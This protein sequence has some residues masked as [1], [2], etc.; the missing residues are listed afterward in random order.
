MFGCVKKLFRKKRKYPVEK[1]LSYSTSY[2]IMYNNFTYNSKSIEDYS[3]KLANKISKEDRYALV[4]K[5]TGMPRELVGCIHHLEGEGDFTR[6]LHNGESL[7]NVNKHGTRLEPKHRGKGLNWSWEQAAIDAINL[8]K[9]KFP[10]LWSA[11][12]SLDFLEKYNGTGYRKRGINSPYLWSYTNYYTKGKY[13]SDGKFSATAVSKQ[14][15]AACILRKLNYLI[16]V[17]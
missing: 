10:L 6:V 14:L 13:V 15:G 5:A 8:E 7:V 4:E 1:A 12:S 17:D 16:I 3:E 9:R 2:Q 11:G